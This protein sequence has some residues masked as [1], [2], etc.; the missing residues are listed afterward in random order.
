MDSIFLALL[1]GV[2]YR[3]IKS[4]HDVLCLFELGP[5]ILHVL[6]LN[7]VVAVGLLPCT[8]VL[9]AQGGTAPYLWPAILSIK[10]HPAKAG[11]S[12]RRVL[13]SSATLVAPESLTP[14]SSPRS[15][16][17]LRELRPETSVRE[18]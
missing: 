18:K 10:A 2:T 12:S 5:N 17:R 3:F 6:R 11:V 16:V 14:H 15:A 13:A 8:K 4:L 1:L 7:E 9:L